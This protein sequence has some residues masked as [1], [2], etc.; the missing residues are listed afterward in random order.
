M[1]SVTLQKVTKT[2]AGG[3]LKAVNGVDLGWT[4]VSS[5]CSWGRPV[6]ANPPCCE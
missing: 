3:Q 5:W 1:A 4:T 2:Y 6:A